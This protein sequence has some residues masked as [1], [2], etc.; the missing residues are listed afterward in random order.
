[1][2][3]WK[4]EEQSKSWELWLKELE[5]FSE[6]PLFFQLFLK[7]TRCKDLLFK[8]LAGLPDSEISTE[9]TKTEAKTK[10]EEEQKAAVQFNYKILS[11]A[12]SISTDFKLRDT[13]MKCGLLPRI[14]DRLAQ[15]SGEKA[16]TFEEEEEPP[17]EEEKQPVES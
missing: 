4:A 10:W 7:N 13:A 8:V 11:E 2:K 14:L 15:I 5:S 16:R 17:K 12:F 6:I 9:G 1:M 3:L